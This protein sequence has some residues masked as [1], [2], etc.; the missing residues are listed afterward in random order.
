MSEFDRLVDIMRTLREPG[1][2]PWDREQTHESLKP[3]VIEEAAEVL[4]GINILRETGDAANLQEELGD[5]LMQVVLHAQ[6][7]QEEGLFD[8]E[9]VCR[10]INEKMIYR[11]PHVFGDRKAQNEGMTSE[12]VLLDWE[13]LKKA[14]KSGR[15]W[16]KDYLP[17]AFDE[18]EELIEKAKK[19]KNIE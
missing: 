1:G 12:E 6:I 11:H 4:G 18:A 14:E 19:R 17:G 7:A 3:T 9:D 15:E 5:L 8:I 10:T 2:C 13:K 16:E